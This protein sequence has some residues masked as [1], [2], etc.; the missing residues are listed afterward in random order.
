VLSANA[1]CLKKACAAFVR[2]MVDD[3]QQINPA[4]SSPELKTERFKASPTI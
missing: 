3:P 1:V 2:Y 4:G